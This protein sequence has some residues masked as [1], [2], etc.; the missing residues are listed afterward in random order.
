MQRPGTRQNFEVDGGGGAVGLNWREEEEEARKGKSERPQS[1]FIRRMD[2]VG[3]CENR[4]AEAV[5]WG[6]TVASIFGR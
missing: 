5:K 1:L 6:A 2:K 3:E 4:G